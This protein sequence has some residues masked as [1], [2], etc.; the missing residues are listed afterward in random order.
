VVPERVD[1]FPREVLAGGLDGAGGRIG[2]DAGAVAGN[3]LRAARKLPST[4]ICSRTIRR[5][6]E[7]ARG[8]A[9]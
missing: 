3:V 5:L 8:E 1:H 6:L 2:E 4:M 7:A 9:K